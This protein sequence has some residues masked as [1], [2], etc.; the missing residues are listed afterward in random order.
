MEILVTQ[1]TNAVSAVEDV[2]DGANAESL[3]SAG[4]T[5]VVLWTPAIVGQARVDW[6]AVAARAITDV[7][8]EA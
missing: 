1:L 8:V 6:L 5:F 2:P 4:H 3:R 7:A